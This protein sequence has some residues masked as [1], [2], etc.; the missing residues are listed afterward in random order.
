MEFLKYKETPLDILLV[1]D[2]PGDVFIIN[3]F[4]KHAGMGTLK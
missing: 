1:E 3:D 2:N 4:I